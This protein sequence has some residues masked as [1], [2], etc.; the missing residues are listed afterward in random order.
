MNESCFYNDQCLDL[1]PH[2]VKA[3]YRRAVICAHDKEFDEACRVASSLAEEDPQSDE[4]QVLLAT[5]KTKQE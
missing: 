5:I 1:N 4:F 2:H 3:R